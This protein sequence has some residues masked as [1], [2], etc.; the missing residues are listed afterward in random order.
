MLQYAPASGQA[1][2]SLCHGCA[3]NAELLLQAA[4]ILGGAE[5]TR[6]AEWVAEDGIERFHATRTPWPSGVPGG[7]ESPNLMLGSAGTG[8]FLLRLYHP[9]AIPPVVMV[10]P[11][12]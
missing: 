8:H 4:R 3:G 11:T 1:N 10:G 2:Y 7:W 6:I 9:E 12:S 5:H